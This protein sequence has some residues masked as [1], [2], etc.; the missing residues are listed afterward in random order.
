M[1]AKAIQLGATA[2]TIG[3]AITRLEIVTDWFLQA[4]QKAAMR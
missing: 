3:S 1:A 2:V 4:T